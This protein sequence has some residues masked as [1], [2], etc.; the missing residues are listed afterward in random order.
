MTWETRKNLPG[1][2]GRP[3]QGVVVNG[4]PAE[5]KFGDEAETRRSSFVSSLIF[6]TFLTLLGRL[7]RR[8]GGYY[9]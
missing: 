1:V 6:H 2:G 4:R 9:K 5:Q 7:V 3:G 8:E